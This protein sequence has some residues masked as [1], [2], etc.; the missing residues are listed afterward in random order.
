MLRSDEELML[1]C[2]DGDEGAFETL[3]RRYEK[4]IFSFIYRMVLSAED[5]EDLCQETFFKVVRAKKK[6]RATAKFK[7]WL[8]HIALNLCRDRI[9]RMKF[10]SHLSLNSPVF[11]QDS[12]QIQ[13]RQSVCDPSSDPTKPAQTAEIKTLVRQ[14]FI[15][16]PEQERTVVILRQYHD[17]KFSEIAEIIDCPVGTAKSL[18]HR[19]REKLMKSLA[20]YVEQ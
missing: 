14:A 11:S 2:R 5:A 17:L 1:S 19:G 15:K 16:L 7:T 6:Y 8:F 10:R 13:L 3:Y 4:P 18:N 9:R 20:K 12:E